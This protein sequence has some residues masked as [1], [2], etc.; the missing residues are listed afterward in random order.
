MILSEEEFGRPFKKVLVKADSRQLL[1]WYVDLGEG[2]T[3]SIKKAK[4]QKMLG[5]GTS[6]MGL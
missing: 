4:M 6:F 1:Q 2:L 5:C 3:I